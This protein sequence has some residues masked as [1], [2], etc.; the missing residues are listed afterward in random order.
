MTRYDLEMV[1]KCVKDFTYA[2]CQGWGVASGKVGPTDAPLEEHIT[3]ND[4]FRLGVDEHHM[5]GRMSRCEPHFQPERTK[6]ERRSRFQP[7]L[8]QV[9]QWVQRNAIQ[10]RCPGCHRVGGLVE[11]MQHGFQAKPP[12]HAMASHDMVQMG[13]GQQHCPGFPTP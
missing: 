1:G 13:V 11:C 12:L 2:A 4:P 6:S 10:V 5:A 7:V 9:R 8:V 3:P